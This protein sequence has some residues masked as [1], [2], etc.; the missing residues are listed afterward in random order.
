MIVQCTQCKTKFRIDP[1]LLERAQARLRCSNCGHVFQAS[2]AVV[3]N[4]QTSSEPIAPL[5]LAVTFCNQ[6]GGVAKT[7]SC[8]NVGI[9]LSRFGYRVLCIDF[10]PQANL[11][12]LAGHSANTGSFYDVVTGTG[13]LTGYIRR[14]PIGIWLL[15]SNQRMNA[16]PKYALQTK[17]SEQILRL[18]L[19]PLRKHFDFVLIDTPPSL[20]FFTLNAI[21][22]ADCIVIPTQCAY[23]SMHGV[24]QIELLI[25]AV[26]ARTGKPKEPRLLFTMYDTNSTA[27][28]A[29]YGLLTQRYAGRTLPYPVPLD[30]AVQEAQILQKTLF[31]HAP[32]GAA[33]QAYLGIAKALVAEYCR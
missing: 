33:A 31:D 14:L 4:L 5:G 30:E 25:N 22:A 24:E 19:E 29:V 20:K 16:F 23:L 7:T 27:A 28:K 1:K 6:K 21:V 15:P 26:R 11:S 9:A 13:D 3:A 8:L 10:D 32:Q 17:N 2:S 12:L 18:A